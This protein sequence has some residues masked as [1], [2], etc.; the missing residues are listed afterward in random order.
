VLL[1]D[2]KENTFMLL[3]FSSS[4]RMYLHGDN[5]QEEIQLRYFMH[6]MHKSQSLLTVKD[7]QQMLVEIQIGGYL[8]QKRI[9]LG[10]MLLGLHLILYRTGEKIPENSSLLE[11]ASSVTI[12]LMEPPKG[13][14]IHGPAGCG[15]TRLMR[16]L[17]QLVGCDFI[18]LPS[19]ILLS[20]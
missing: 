15:K 12:Q 5:Q 8:E 4:L 6:T 13:M 17:V 18:E 14:I 19:S 9:A 1:L 7:M 11:S 3:R 16:S 10:T 2:P 20:K